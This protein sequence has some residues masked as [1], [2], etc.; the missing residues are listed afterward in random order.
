M[1]GHKVT[2]FEP[3]HRGSLYY[4]FGVVVESDIDVQA[5]IRQVDDYFYDRY[6][7]RYIILVTPSA[8]MVRDGGDWVLTHRVH[9]EEAIR[10]FRASNCDETIRFFG[11]N[12][13]TANFNE[14]GHDYGVPPNRIKFNAYYIANSY[15]VYD[16][17]SVVLAHSDTGWYLVA[18]YNEDEESFPPVFLST[19]MDEAEV[20]LKL[21]CSTTDV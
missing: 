17:T 14:Y 5:V 3:V 2:F 7:L 19:D 8:T 16:D 10:F 4:A 6:G 9:P 20:L 1:I 21:M 12:E 11:G 15:F 18:N 13:Y